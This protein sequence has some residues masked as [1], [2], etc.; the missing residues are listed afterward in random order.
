[1]VISDLLLD[2]GATIINIAI[3]IFAITVWILQKNMYM[4][5]NLISVLCVQKSITHD[6][7]YLLRASFA[8]TDE[9]KATQV[10]SSTNLKNEEIEKLKK[11]LKERKNYQFVEKITIGSFAIGLGLTLTSLAIKLLIY[12]LPSVTTNS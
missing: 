11:Y 2:A 4:H 3:A 6:Y 1:M 12:V 8:L 7:F 9:E 10:Y 5:D